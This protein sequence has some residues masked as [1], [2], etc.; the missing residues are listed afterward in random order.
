MYLPVTGV[1][2]GFTVTV[3]GQQL[4]CT[5]QIPGTSDTSQQY[6]GLYGNVNGNP[7]DDLTA[8]N[9]SVLPTN[10]SDQQIFYLFG[11][12]CMPYF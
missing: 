2:A 3:G 7:A 11:Q 4:Q 9:G 5:V 10:A 1:G 6:A 12:T 8:S